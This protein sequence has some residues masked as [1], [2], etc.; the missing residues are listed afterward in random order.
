MASA[1]TSGWKMGGTGWPRRG[2]R[3]FTQSNCG[4][5]SAGSCTIVTRMALPSWSSSA[6]SESQN[7][8]TACLPAQY[9]DC[10]G[11]PR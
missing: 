3:L 4:V 2:R 1:A 11:M 7:P 9:A 10:S 8:C 5:F 6:R